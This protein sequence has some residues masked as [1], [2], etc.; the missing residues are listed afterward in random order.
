METLLN[1]ILG[2]V[3]LLFVSTAITLVGG[4][5]ILQTLDER[6]NYKKGQINNFDT[7][8]K[9]SGMGGRGGPIDTIRGKNQITSNEPSEENNPNTNQ[10]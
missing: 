1:I 2:L 10:K 6:D 8:T 9:V 7:K 3:F 5:F 4:W